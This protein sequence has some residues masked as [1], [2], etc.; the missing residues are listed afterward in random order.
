MKEKLDTAKN[1]GFI[2]KLNKIDR[3]AANDAKFALLIR[4]SSEVKFD[5]D[6]H[7][8]TC[9]LPLGQVNQLLN[10]WT[11]GWDSCNL[12]YKKYAKQSK[13]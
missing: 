7:A 10:A 12:E 3:V 13:S 2:A 8:Y 6:G 11:L 1:L 4:T 5:A 9:T